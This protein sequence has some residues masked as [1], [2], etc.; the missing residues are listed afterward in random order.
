MA[1]HASSTH[2][3]EVALLVSPPH[4]SCHAL[5]LSSG[6]GKDSSS[7]LP[8]RFMLMS[9]LVLLL[10]VSGARSESGAPWP[11]EGGSNLRH[12]ASPFVHARTPDA[13]AVRWKENGYLR[14]PVLAPA[15]VDAA[16]KVYFATSNPAEVY[17]IAI[18]NDEPDSETSDV[19]GRERLWYAIISEKG[20]VEASPVL[21]QLDTGENAT[22]REIIFVFVNEE[23]D[24][25][26]REDNSAIFAFWCGFRRA[27]ASRFPFFLTLC[28][29]P[30]TQGQTNPSARQRPA[31]STHS[32]R[33]GLL[34]G[35]RPM[36]PRRDLGLRTG[37]V[38]S[39]ST[40][41][42]SPCCTGARAAAS[43][44]RQTGV[45]PARSAARTDC[46]PSPRSMA[47]R[48]GTSRRALGSDQPRSS[49][50]HSCTRSPSACSTV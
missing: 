40:S 35:F 11:C 45:A 30:R 39:T 7:G 6:L 10:S 47:H 15:V 16:G 26:T 44:I 37:R 17:A 27:R 24:P 9:L 1:G 3:P 49:T 19:E 13:P 28:V 22:Q 36:R 18:R 8:A 23:S 46:G 50:E 21:G 25:E 5:A 32:T 34:G 20:F 14:S 29:C 4:V 31:R 12:S 42:V 43:S 41:T 48:S 2:T 33:R 38:P